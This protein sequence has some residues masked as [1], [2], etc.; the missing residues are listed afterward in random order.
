VGVP[1][2]IWRGKLTTDAVM[3]INGLLHHADKQD[4]APVIGQYTRMKIDWSQA[5]DVRT[6]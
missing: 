2:F 1:I 5:H 3:R 6:P 4:V